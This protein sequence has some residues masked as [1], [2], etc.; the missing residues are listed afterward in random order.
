MSEVADNKTRNCPQ[1]GSSNVA[2]ILWGMPAYD[3]ELEKKLA[4]GS[5]VLGG[6]CISPADPDWHCNDC[7]C[8]FG[9]RLDAYER[10]KEMKRDKL[11]GVV[12]GAAVG[13]ALGVP[14]EFMGR[15]SFECTEMIGGG[16]HGRPAGTYS[17]DTSLL[18]ATCASIKEKGAI[19]L[20][21]MRQ[22]FRSW[23]RDGAFT[24]D[25][26][27]FDVGN[28]TATALDQGYGC[29]GERSNGNGSLMRIAPLA[30]LTTSDNDVRAVSA[31]THAHWMSTE[32]CV[33]FVRILDDLVF[34]E[35]LEDAI[36][37]NA[38]DSKAFAFLHELEDAPREQIRSGGFVLD[39]L[40]AALWCALHTDNFRDCVL[41]AVNLGDDT[42]TTACVAGAVAGAIYGYDSIPKEWIVR[43]RGKDVIE[44][45]LFL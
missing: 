1:C 7:G 6:C 2:E 38:P 27:V 14:Y 43:L 16:S 35:Y 3:E 39:T 23:L 40:G 36:V 34:G 4:D 19:D 33:A 26:V 30:F 22:K 25:G 20:D 28:A 18:L 45:S 17:D 9:D 5:V 21:D 10:L 44:D 13:D 32:A 11:K 41:T 42:D 8:E 15:D 24:P 12:Y 31:I 29:D 37:A